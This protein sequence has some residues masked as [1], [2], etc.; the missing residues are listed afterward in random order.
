MLKEDGHGSLVLNHV[1][2]SKFPRPL[3]AILDPLLKGARDPKSEI[4]IL[5]Y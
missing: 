5:Q 3:Q 2:K 4:L 1:I